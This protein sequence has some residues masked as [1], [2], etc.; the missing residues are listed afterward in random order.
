MQPDDG[1]NPPMDDGLGGFRPDD[2]R[3]RRGLGRPGRPRK[4]RRAKTGGAMKRYGHA[5]LSREKGEASQDRRGL[6]CVG[7][8]SA[9]G[10]VV[11]SATGDAFV[12]TKH[13]LNRRCFWQRCL[14]YLLNRRCFVV[15]AT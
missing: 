3:E 11:F 9:R 10:L 7:A 8:E 14:K 1:L 4:A 15:L 2:G 12:T 5:L 6:S 13:L